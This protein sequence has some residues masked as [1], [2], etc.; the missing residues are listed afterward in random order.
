MLKTW[1]GLYAVLA[2]G[3]TILY[4]AMKFTK[5]EYFEKGREPC[6]VTPHSSPSLAGVSSKQLH[7]VKQWKTAFNFQE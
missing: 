5:R 4:E 6:E 2:K 1:K 3:T 7:P